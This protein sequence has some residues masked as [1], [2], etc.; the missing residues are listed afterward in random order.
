MAPSKTTKTSPAAK[1]KKEGKKE[2]IFHPSSRKAV[3]LARTAHRKDRLGD[4]ASKRHK[5]HNSL[6]TMVYKIIDTTLTP[7]QLTYMDFS[8]TQYQRMGC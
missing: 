4:L 6:G 2:K 1:P 8:I 7:R 5:K 3:Q